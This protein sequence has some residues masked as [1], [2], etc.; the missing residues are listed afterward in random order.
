MVATE[1][2][3]FARQASAGGCGANELDE[4]IGSLSGISAKLIYL[5]R[6]GLNQQDRFVL[7][8]LLDGCCDDTWVGGADGINACFPR[9]AILI[10]NILQELAR[11]VAL[12]FH[13]FV[14]LFG[15]SLEQ[16]VV[17]ERS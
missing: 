13:R 15:P 2:D 17:A 12:G 8:G 10:D 6:R 5:T 16:Q 9:A 14:G 3:T 4:L 7:N 11:I 1:Q